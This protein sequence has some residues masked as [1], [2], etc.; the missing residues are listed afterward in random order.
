MA[1]NNLAQNW[2][3]RNDQIVLLLLGGMTQK[4]V[5]GQFK[6]TR[7]AISKIANDPRATEV[8]TAARESIT[9]KL[10]SDMDDQMTHAARL[11]I[12]SIRRTLEADINPVHKAKGNQDRVAVAV[13]RGRGFLTQETAEGERSL[14]MT[15][16]Q[17][18]RLLGAMK[19]SDEV[20]GID[21]FADIPEA[22]AV[23]VGVDE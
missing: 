3:I 1:T 19:K 9:E 22:E 11:A 15:P 14:Q 4:E 20:K 5:A 2:P 18:D 7:Q 10:L 21:P 23:E 17:Y 13:L 12:K 8:I 16:V 6:L